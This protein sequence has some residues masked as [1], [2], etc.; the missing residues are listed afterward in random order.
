MKADIPA[1]RAEQSVLGAALLAPR[2]VDELRDWLPP[3]AFRSPDHQRIWEVMLDEPRTGSDFSDRVYT[4]LQQEPHPQA[5]AYHPVRLQDLMQACWHPDRAPLYGGMVLEAGI[6]RGLETTGIRLEQTARQATVDSAEAALS[7]AAALGLDITDLAARWEQVPDRVRQALAPPSGHTAVLPHPPT[8]RHQHAD[9]A[10]E[11]SV[12]GGIL[13]DP[14]QLPQARWLHR[15]DFSDQCHAETWDALSRLDGYGVPIDPMTVEWN[16]QRAGAIQPDQPGGWTGGD[17]H[18]W[19]R[20]G[21]PL[22][23]EHFATQVGAAGALDRTDLAGRR[24]RALTRL[25]DIAPDDLLETGVAVVGQ[26]PQEQRRLAPHLTPDRGPYEIRR[27][28]P[29]LVP[30]QAST[31]DHDL[32]P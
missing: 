14:A 31:H 7:R 24:L 12:I 17:L 28:V 5:E 8:L 13:A 32:T 18:Q 1:T 19:A 25:P 10:A 21:I 11:R 15:D 2:V 20:E 26:L 30:A 16:L 6:H 3:G 27:T 22:A 9:P 23:V 29:E 4:R